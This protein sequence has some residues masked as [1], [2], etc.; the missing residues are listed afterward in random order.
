MSPPSPSDG[1]DQQ[2]ALIAAE[3]GSLGAMIQQHE[4]AVDLLGVL[5]GDYF[6]VTAHRHVFEAI[7][8]LVN[9]GH[10]V[11]EITVLGQLRTNQ[12]L[13][14][15]GGPAAIGEL[16]T[17]CPSPA[18]ARSYAHQV[19]DEHLRRTVIQLGNTVA[20][21]TSAD[22]VRAVLDV[23]SARIHHLQAEHHRRRRPAAR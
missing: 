1:S 16:V 9:D 6:S 2:Q 4:V 7:R 8:D 10:G 20:A 18:N 11:D 21:E 22:H 5:D 23:L 17:A 12:T 13:T 3:M 19:L 14:D 15:A